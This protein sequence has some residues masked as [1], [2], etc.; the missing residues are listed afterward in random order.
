MATSRIGRS[1]EKKRSQ[2]PS[3]WRGYCTTT[4]G[5]R[6]RTGIWGPS[7]TG[8]RGPTPQPKLCDGALSVP[9]VGT[10]K[11]RYHRGFS[12][13]WIIFRVPRAQTFAEIGKT[14]SLNRVPSRIGADIVELLRN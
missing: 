13:N 5:R 12:R 3:G 2:R 10:F 14:L 9:Q 4:G 11:T 8:E 7:R 6:S 1:L